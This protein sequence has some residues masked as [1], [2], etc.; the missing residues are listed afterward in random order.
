MR[1]EACSDLQESQSDP[2]LRQ[3]GWVQAFPLDVSLSDEVSD[4]LRRIPNSACCSTHDVHVSCE[5]RVI[6]RSAELK[7]C[8]TSGVQQVTSSMRSGGEQKRRQPTD[9]AE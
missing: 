5:G 3:G 4:V 9:T 8:G 2:D 1:R 7:S 6:R